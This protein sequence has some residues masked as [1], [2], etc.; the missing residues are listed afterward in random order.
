MPKTAPPVHPAQGQGNGMD[1]QS[2]VEAFIVQSH[3]GNAFPTDFRS[4]R[5]AVRTA[6][7]ALALACPNCLSTVF[8][9]SGSNDHVLRF[10]C[11]CVP[12]VVFRYRCM[13]RRAQRVVHQHRP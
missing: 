13:F 6:L 4:E 9:E 11:P 7:R 2:R 1:L 5:E 8:D 12:H 3:G 10:K